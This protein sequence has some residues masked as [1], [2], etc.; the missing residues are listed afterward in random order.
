VWIAVDDSTT[1]N[2]CL[3][4]I[5]GSHKDKTLRKHQI[6]NGPGLALNQELPLTDIDR[7][8]ISEIT[9]EAGQ[10]SLHDVHLVHGSEPN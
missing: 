2:G 8:N 1:E 10:I 9:L 4:V 7:A 3:Q 5:R 6:N